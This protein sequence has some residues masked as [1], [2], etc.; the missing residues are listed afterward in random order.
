MYIR[1]E[2]YYKDGNFSH[3]GNVLLDNLSAIQMCGQWYHGNK[4]TNQGCVTK[5]TS[6]I[7]NWGLPLQ[8]IS[9][10]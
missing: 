10:D 2:A 8:K 4:A 5:V 7:D 1:F 6:C 3:K 9:H